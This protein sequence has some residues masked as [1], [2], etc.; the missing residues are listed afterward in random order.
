MFIPL[1]PRDQE[2]SRTNPPCD[3]T[4]PKSTATAVP[5]A[6]ANANAIN[7]ILADVNPESHT[8]SRRL[9]TS[10]LGLLSCASLADLGRLGALGSAGP[11]E[12]AKTLQPH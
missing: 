2:N 9:P 4:V 8:T 5:F 12:L 10:G 3:A 1:C 7:R 11:L 6:R